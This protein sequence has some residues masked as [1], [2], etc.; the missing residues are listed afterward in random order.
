MGLDCHHADGAHPGLRG[1]ALQRA[2]GMAEAR[3]LEN[4]ERLTPPRR[5]VLELLLGSDGP[6]KAYDLIAAFA[7]GAPANRL[8]SI[9]PWSSW[10][11]WASPIGSRA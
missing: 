4:Q 11:G 6:L 10:S 2:L 5:R 7:D 9:A 1:H 8:P 3:C